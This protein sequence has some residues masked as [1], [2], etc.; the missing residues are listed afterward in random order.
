MSSRSLQNVQLGI[1][2]R[3]CATTGKKCTK[4]RDPH[5]K[6]LFCQ[7]KPTV[8]LPFLLSSSLSLLKLHNIRIGSPIGRTALNRII[9]VIT[10]LEVTLT[11]G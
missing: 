2:S 5:P 6:L 7:S 10:V 1:S 11:G 9:Q 8:F 4:K 3:S